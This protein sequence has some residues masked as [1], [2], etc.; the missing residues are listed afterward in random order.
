V[1][2]FDSMGMGMKTSNT[3]KLMN[4]KKKMNFVQV[5]Y[6]NVNNNYIPIY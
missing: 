6:K 3:R 2:S 5:Q 1:N 4:G